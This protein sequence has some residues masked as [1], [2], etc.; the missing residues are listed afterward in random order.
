MRRMDR[1]RYQIIREQDPDVNLFET[2]TH[3][4]CSEFDDLHSLDATEL[5]RPMDVRQEHGALNDFRM[6][7]RRRLDTQE[8]LFLLFEVLGGAN[9]GGQGQVALA[10]NYGI[11][12]GTLSNYIRHSLFAV[13]KCLDSIEPRLISWPSAEERAEMHGLIIGFPKCV[14]FVDGNKTSR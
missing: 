8:V 1:H 2:L 4:T 11:S 6:P 7:R 13:F 3:F 14:F 10:H 12:T 9:E 5:A